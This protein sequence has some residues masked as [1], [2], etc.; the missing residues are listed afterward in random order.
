MK[1]LVYIIISILLFTSCKSKQEST[2]ALT[3]SISE[4]VY[5]SGVVKSKNQYQVYATVNGLIKDILV[6]EGDIIKKGQPIIGITNTASKLNAENAKLAADFSDLN[7]NTDKL[8]ELKSTIDFA[9]SKMKNDS[10]LLVRQNNLWTNKVG[11]QNDLDQRELAYK[12][13]KSAYES[14]LLRYNSLQKQLQFEALKSKMNLQ[15]SNTI[16]EDYLIKSETDGKIYSIFKEPGE[17]VT[18]QSPVALIGD[19]N[20]FLLELQV[21]EYDITKI[22]I[23]QKILVSLDSYKGKTFEARVSKINPSMNERSRSFTIDAKFITKPQLLFPNLTAESNIV[24]QTKENALTIP[25]NY[26][27]DDNYVLNENKEKV[28]VA[29]GLK[30][31]QKAEIISGLKSGEVILKPTK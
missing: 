1:S 4:S 15:I 6:T 28:K 24:I 31:Y 12:N 2:K 5:A 17:M 19:A 11:S 22:K 18:V 20:E 13:S 25:R 16:E 10:N 8:N 7:A 23:G 14:A 9:Y 26:L 27:I 30:D 29:V 21:D 3:E